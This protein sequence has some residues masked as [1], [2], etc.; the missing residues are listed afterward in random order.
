[1]FL[2]YAMQMVQIIWQRV[3]MPDREADGKFRLLKA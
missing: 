2:D 3:T 1:M